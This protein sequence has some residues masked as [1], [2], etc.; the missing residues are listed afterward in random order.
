MKTPYISAYGSWLSPITADLIVQETIGL[1]QARWD[2]DDLYWLESRPAESGRSVLVQQSAG[3]QICD[4]LPP[5]WNVRSRV[6]EYGGAAFTVYQGTV[7]FVNFADQR[8]YRQT[9]IAEP[10]PITPEGPYRYADLQYDHYHHQLI[11]VRENHSTAGEPINTIVSINLNNPQEQQILAAGQDFYASITLSPD[12]GK[13]AWL[14]WNHPSMPWYGNQLWMAKWQADGMLSTA[15]VVAGGP[16][17]SI[18]QPLWGPGGNLYFVSDR[19]NWWNLYLWDGTDVL[20]MY[21]MEAEF[22][23]PQWVFGS[24]TYGFTDAG[25]LICTHSQNGLWYLNKL[26]EGKLTTLELP[27]TDIADPQV[28]GQQVVFI[29]GAAKTPTALVKLDLA[30]GEIFTIRQ[31]SQIQLDPAY[32]SQPEPIIFPTND[33]KVAYGFFYPPCNPDYT[34]PPGTK[35]PLV[36]RCHGGPTAAA[37]SSLSL[38]RIQYWTSRGF[39]LLDV[40]YGGST[41]FGREYRC[42]LDGSWGVVDVDDCVNGAR[43]LVEQD[44]VDPEKLAIAGGSAGGYT[45]LAALT[46]RDVFKAGAS[47]YGVSDLEALARDTHKFEAHY[48]DRLIGPYPQQE[49]LYKERSPINFVDQLNCP[50]IFFQGLEDLVVPPNQTEIIVEALRR[51]NIPVAYLAYPGEQHGFRRAENIKRTLEAELYFYSQ[52][53]K[54]PLAEKIDPVEIHGMG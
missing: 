22:G 14:S 4:R 32:F 40:N 29:A 50:V 28:Q 27:Y 42:R 8:I 51:R 35:P 3:G 39:A 25:E 12:G 13:L 21:T 48:L 24:S 19:S 15:Q 20:P 33:D 38:G 7:Y 46:F 23:L 11:A 2:G 54:F 53:F 36:V 10:E 5:P 44:W 43:Y 41:G 31:S 18:F 30:T 47:Y 37:S 1:G 52:I 6:H 26:H 45:A 49:K 17:E 34:G 9:G 16:E